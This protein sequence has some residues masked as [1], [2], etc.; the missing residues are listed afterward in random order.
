M[1]ER[2]MRSGMHLQRHRVGL[3]DH[4]ARLR[5]QLLGAFQILCVAM[6]ALSPVVALATP[7]P[8]DRRAF[9][10]PTVLALGTLAQHLLWRRHKD[11]IVSH[12][13]VGSLLVAMAAGILLNGILAP[14]S[15]IPMLCVLLA[16]YL[17]G[18]E[19]AWKAGF[20]SIAL[21]VGGYLATRL[22][23]VPRLVVP[24][25]VWARVVAI[26]IVVSAGILA[27][28]LRGLLSGV[29]RIEQ[30]RAALDESVHALERH[31]ARLTKEV[32]RRTRDLERANSDLMVFSSVL[33]DELNP[34]LRS[35]QDLAEELKLSAPLSA[36]QIDLLERIQE[37]TSRLDRELRKA[38]RTSRVDSSS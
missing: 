31:R 11:R 37:G 6:V 28:P 17:L 20:A 5:H 18:R 22:G 23:L 10:P 4:D 30:E 3:I 36:R 35:I 13:I 12:V 9:I 27:L 7:G 33:S 19:A 26:Q 16:G 32:A 38:F 1:L 8:L 34:R 21:L 24:L 15:V 29:R 2:Q 14:S 25:G